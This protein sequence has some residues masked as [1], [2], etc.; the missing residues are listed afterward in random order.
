VGGASGLEL[1][2][3]WGGLDSSAMRPWDHSAAKVCLQSNGEYP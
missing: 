3:D 2:G 1:S